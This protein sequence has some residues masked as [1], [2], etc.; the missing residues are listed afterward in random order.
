[1]NDYYAKHLFDRSALR[2]E[3]HARLL[4]ARLTKHGDFSVVQK[5]YLDF[6]DA[7]DEYVRAYADFWDFVNTRVPKEQQQYPAWERYA[8]PEVQEAMA[9]HREVYDVTPSFG[10]TVINGSHRSSE[11]Y[12]L[13]RWARNAAK[14]RR[15]AAKLRKATIAE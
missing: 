11:A 5:A 10:I 14:Y 4:A 12:P 15:G 1:M 7:H 9:V 8:P 2:Q 3:S 6:A 13:S